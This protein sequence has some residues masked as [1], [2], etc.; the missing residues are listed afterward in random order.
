MTAF[1]ELKSQYASIKE[2]IDA[3]I[4]NTLSSGQFV[5]G[6]TVSTFEEEFARYCDVKYCIAT[7]SGTSALFLA[8]AACDIGEG[9]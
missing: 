2:E 6:E 5:L 1:L 3:A 4:Q 7:S 8:L 9:D